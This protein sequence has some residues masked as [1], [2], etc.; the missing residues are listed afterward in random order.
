MWQTFTYYAALALES[1]VGVF[2]IRLYE[3][4]RYAVE[5]DRA[6]ARMRDR[7]LP[8]AQPEAPAA[9]IVPYDVE[10]EEGEAVV[11]VHD[12]DGRGWRARVL[13]D[14]KPRRIDAGET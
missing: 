13:A 14:E 2:G 9:Q 3:E 10:A 1:V 12:R 4:P 7:R 8:G 11:V 6:R 5:A